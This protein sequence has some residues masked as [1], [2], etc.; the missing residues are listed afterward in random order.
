MLSNYYQAIHLFRFDAKSGT[1]YIL[2]AES[3]ELVISRDG[4]WRFL[5]E[6]EF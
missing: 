1:I 5:D 3:L 6:A 4:T 2:A